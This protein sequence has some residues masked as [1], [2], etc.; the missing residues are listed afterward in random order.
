V[1]AGQVLKLLKHPRG[2]IQPALFW[3]IADAPADLL[4]DRLAAPAHLAAVETGDSDDG[5]HGGGLARSVR[6]E[7][8]EDLAG[9]DGEAQSVQGDHAAVPAAQVIQL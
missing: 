1:P 9:R 4:A 8:P 6:P 5:P 7:E 3:H 2:G